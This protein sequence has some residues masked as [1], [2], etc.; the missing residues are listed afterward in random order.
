MIYYADTSALTKRYL[1]EDG[2]VRIQDCLAQGEYLLTSFLTK[3]ELTSAIERAKRSARINSPT[4]RNVIA[5]FEYD[6]RNEA[7]SFVHISPHII[8][9]AS[10]FIRTRRLS[11]PDAI[12]LASA[13][14]VQPSANDAYTFLCADR[15]LL[16]AARLEGLRCI[17]PTR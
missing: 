17:D 11:P 14:E 12:Q 5:T 3:L 9:V 7:F 4:Y 1:D 13:L 10:R 15:C 2:S 8:N 6:L 16:D